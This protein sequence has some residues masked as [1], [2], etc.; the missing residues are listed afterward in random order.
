M[1]PSGKTPRIEVRFAIDADSK[2]TPIDLAKCGL[3][4]KQAAGIALKI[5]NRHSRLLACWIWSSSSGLLSIAK[6]SRLRLPFRKISLPALQGASEC[7]Q[8]DF[9]HGVLWNSFQLACIALSLA[10]CPFALKSAARSPPAGVT[11]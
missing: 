10:S 1:K 2:H 3:H 9:C 7:V 6:A 5:A 4:F 8:F 11:I